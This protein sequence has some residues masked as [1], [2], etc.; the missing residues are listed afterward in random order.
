MH[1]GALI[2]L[3]ASS[4]GFQLLAHLNRAMESVHSEFVDTSSKGPAHCG[5]IPYV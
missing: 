4:E 1:E 5:I 3:A 2:D